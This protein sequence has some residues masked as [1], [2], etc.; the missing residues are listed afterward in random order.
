M[1]RAGDEHS[2]ALFARIVESGV[3]I[4]DDVGVEMECLRVLA[5]LGE[6]PGAAR[7]CGRRHRQ[8]E[9]RHD[10]T[11]D[12]NHLTPI[13]VAE[14]TEDSG[15][16]SRRCNGNERLRQHLRAR[17]IVCDVENELAN[18][19][20]AP[21][22]AHGVEMAR[23][24]GEAYGECRPARVEQY[25]REGQICRLVVADKRRAQRA[26][27]ATPVSVARGASVVDLGMRDSNFAR[28][29]ANAR[30]AHGLRARR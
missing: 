6:I 21:R 13:L 30:G 16:R 26:R 29:H 11:E 22:D 4:F 24:L 2:G 19:L 20:K 9:V 5:H 28:D 27:F 7:G 12:A 18:V 23:R 8:H 14:H 3:E 10:A 17:R 15:D 1:K 25:E